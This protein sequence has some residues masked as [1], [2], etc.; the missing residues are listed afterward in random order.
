MLVAGFTVPSTGFVSS[1]N[2]AV[3]AVTT[4]PPLVVRRGA[5]AMDATATATLAKGTSSDP[6][7]CTTITLPKPLRIRLEEIRPGFPGARILARL[8]L[9]ADDTARLLGAR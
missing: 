9:G 6:R 1:P 2:A 8:H 4:R 5:V 7:V 3:P